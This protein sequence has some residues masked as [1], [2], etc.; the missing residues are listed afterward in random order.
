MIS[1]CDSVIFL[2]ANIAIN[3][4][5]LAPKTFYL[6]AYNEVFLNSK[7]PVFDRSRLYGA[8]G[9]VFNKHFRFELGFMRQM[10]A[11]NSRNQLQIVV[12]GNY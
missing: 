5:T 6:S 7:N 8:G 4:K 2:A 9:Y 10:L 3:N 1:E 11:A 12:F